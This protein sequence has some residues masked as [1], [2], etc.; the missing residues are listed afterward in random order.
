MSSI[1]LDQLTG[2]FHGIT[3]ENDV[4]G[5]HVKYGF[6]SKVDFTVETE[7]QAQY[8]RPGAEFTNVLSPF[9]RL[10]FEMC[11]DVPDFSGINKAMMDSTGRV[12][13]RVFQ[14]AVR[15]TGKYRPDSLGEMADELT[16]ATGE[17][18]FSVLFNLLRM[19]LFYKQDK[20]KIEVS[21]SQKFYD[22]GH[23]AISYGKHLREDFRPWTEPEF[24]DY[25]GSVKVYNPGYP[26]GPHD[27]FPSLKLM[28]DNEIQ[29][30]LAACWG[31]TFDYPLRLMSSTPRVIENFIVPR[32]GL[33][34]TIGLEITPELVLQT[35]RKFV[36]ANRL[37]AQFDL[38]YYMVAATLLV[39]IPRAVEANAWVSPIHTFNLPWASTIRGAVPDLLAKDPYNS[40]PSSLLTWENFN[41]KQSR[42]LIHAIA[43][44]E[45][46]Y[47]GLF[48][49]MTAQDGYFDSTL[50]NMGLAGSG[51][52]SPYLFTLQ[53]AAYRF[54]KEFE[55]K[56]ET[57]A[58]PDFAT[59]VIDAQI[60]RPRDVWVDI[61]G[62]VAGYLIL[63][64]EINGVPH[65]R[66]QSRD[67]KPVLHPILSIGINDQRYY[68][69]AHNY[70]AELKVSPTTGK[71][72]TI[73]GDQANKFMS[74]LRIGGY[75]V[76]MRDL[77]T[78]LTH[79]NWAANSN[80]HVMPMFSKS[81]DGSTLYTVVPDS[82]KK[83][84]NNWINID[85]IVDRL[86]VTVNVEP[87]MHVLRINGEEDTTKCHR[88]KPLVDI[89]NKMDS[90][91]GTGVIFKTKNTIGQYRY[92][93]FILADYRHP[94]ETPVYTLEDI[95]PSEYTEQ[96]TGRE[97]PPEAPD[98]E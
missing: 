91:G 11:E 97:Q 77:D 60:A 59:P 14:D 52:D 84:K 75:D 6:K 27:Y 19:Y 56:Q 23:V 49:L 51:L 35:L 72:T 94:G 20:S 85:G 93:D 7:Y 58:G 26:M 63:K 55:V 24:N 8:T 61:V 83:R 86:K 62:D 9:G 3:P 30:L 87:Y 45:A 28:H 18:H 39:P 66:V 80:G 21:P 95:R 37:H 88:Y 79:L 76:L 81:E 54:G 67:A 89:P 10:S 53:C 47:T 48:E 92:S 90:G 41:R 38:A 36:S 42:L 17:S 31:W 68:I 82:M 16:S 74:I 1:L 50:A 12:D 43:L 4:I 5:R 34:T 15:H 64:H 32:S 70:S 25:S 69:N 73:S 96:L 46:V 22:D 98:Q 29:V 33:Y 2:P 40:A 78:G 65:Y 71:L 44:T 57:C 13:A